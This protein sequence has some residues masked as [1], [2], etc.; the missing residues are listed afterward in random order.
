MKSE[1]LTYDEILNRS[2]I[3]YRNHYKRWALVLLIIGIISVAASY[4]F[5]KGTRYS[6]IWVFILIIFASYS[7]Y[8]YIM[9]KVSKKGIRKYIEPI[10]NEINEFN[11]VF[12]G[13]KEIYT[14]NHIIVTFLDY[15]GV[16]CVRVVEINNI[17]SIKTKSRKYQ[18]GY[19]DFSI[20]YKIGR[21]DFLIL[22]D[23]FK[24]IL[25]N[26]IVENN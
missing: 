14:R 16:K 5:A 6:S 25:K 20:Y 23:V 22:P 7:L 15:E 11:L 13:Y 10:K 12:D 19:S 3:D 4:F 8:F 1:T 9:S 2:I 17:E 21:P 24:E 18:Q 26:Y